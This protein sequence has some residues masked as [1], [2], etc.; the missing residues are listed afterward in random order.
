MAE[1]AAHERNQ[2]RINYVIDLIISDAAR[3]SFQA[4]KLI[5]Q[6]VMSQGLPNEAKASEKVQINIG[7]TYHDLAKEKPVKQPDDIKIIP[8]I[9]ENEEEEDGKGKQAES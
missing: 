4:Q 8:T 9:I 2:D 3:G 5:W 7:T 1:E 6:T